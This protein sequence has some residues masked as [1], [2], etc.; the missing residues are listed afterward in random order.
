MKK[1][2]APIFPLSPIK[3]MEDEKRYC[4]P[5][6]GRKCAKAIAR[7]LLLLDLLSVLSRKISMQHRTITSYL[8]VHSFHIVLVLLLLFAAIARRH[9]A[10]TTLMHGCAEQQNY[11]ITC[12][13]MFDCLCYFGKPVNMSTTCAC[14]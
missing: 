5:Y 2:I 10:F 7:L 4:R 6:T 11:S 12:P 3:L 8:S 1:C 14:V 9:A 13:S